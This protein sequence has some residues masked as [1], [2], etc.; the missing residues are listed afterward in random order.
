ML[1]AFLSLLSHVLAVQA[2]RSL[3]SGFV[4]KKRGNRR[5]GGEEGNDA[6]KKGGRGGK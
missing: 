3:Q 1:H 5:V 6:W 4:E 2:S